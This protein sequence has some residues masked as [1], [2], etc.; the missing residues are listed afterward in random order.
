MLKHNDLSNSKQ[1]VFPNLTL[2]ATS[3]VGCRSEREFTDLGGRRR[4]GCRDGTLPTGAQTQVL[5]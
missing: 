5:W 4:S 3:L 1:T 2:T